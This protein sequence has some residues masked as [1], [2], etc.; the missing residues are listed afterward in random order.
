MVAKEFFVNYYNFNPICVQ[1]ASIHVKSNQCKKYWYVLKS[2]K[3]IATGLVKHHLIV[4]VHYL[5]FNL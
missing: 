2:K 1:H 3:V 5:Y 4:T